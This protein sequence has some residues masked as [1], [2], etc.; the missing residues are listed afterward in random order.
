MEYIIVI[1]F[2]Y[3]SGSIPFGLII[4]KIFTG[5]DIRNIG[6]GNIGATNVLTNWEKIL[7]YN[8]F[9]TSILLKGMSPLLP[10]RIF[11]L[12]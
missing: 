12:N 8:N 1:F 9:T 11:F 5:K 7:S 6:S 10:L 2:S 3:L 4:T